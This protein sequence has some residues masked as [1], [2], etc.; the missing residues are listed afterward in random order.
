MVALRKITGHPVSALA[1]IIISFAL[2]W[3]FRDVILVILLAMLLTL[4]LLPVVDWLEQQGVRRWLAAV[5]PLT[6]SVLSIAWLISLVMPKLLQ[7]AEA[8]LAAAPDV[9]HQLS[10]KYHLHANTQEIATNSGQAI[11]TATFGAA[12]FL[13]F[14]AVVLFFSLYWLIDYHKI[15]HSLINF[16]EKKHR[17]HVRELSTKAEH[18]VQ[19]W[20]RGQII[21]SLVVGVVVASAYSFIGLP[22]AVVLGVLAGLLEIVPFLGPIL[23]AIPAFVLGM[24][25]SPGMGLAVFITYAIVQTAE[26]NLLAPKIMSEAVN[27]H[28]L[29]VILS[30]MI[31]AKLAGFIGILLA[32]PVVLILTAAFNVYHDILA[33]E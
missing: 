2:A 23:A 9:A 8:L 4:S 27:L 26:S 6:V 16:L 32:I 19:A 1:L 24:S 7:Q 25:I 13:G 15:K 28:P 20:V 12:S 29:A 21:L 11:I 22:F 17:K 30:F 3:F 18:Q 14:L 31:G 33:K 10:Q 5:T